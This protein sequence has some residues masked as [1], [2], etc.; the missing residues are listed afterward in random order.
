MMHRQPK[1]Y[2]NR[3]KLTDSEQG[4]AV[5]AGYAKTMLENAPIFPL[6]LEYK[7][8]DREMLNFCNNNVPIIIKGKKVPTFT[9][10]S[11]QRFSE[12]SQ[13]WKYT[14]E[15]NNILLNFK[16]ITRENN[17]KK[18]TSHGN[19]W[20]I[21]G[22]NRQTL[23]IRDVLDDNGTESYE[24][25]SMCQPFTVDIQYRISFVTD[26]FENLNEF[27]TIF[28]NLFKSRQFYIRPNGH[29][30]PLTLEDISDS[31]EYT[32]SDLKLY[33]QTV[34]I[35]CMAYIIQEKDFKI[36][37]VPKNHKLLMQGDTKSMKPKINLEEYYQDKIENVSIDLS[38][39]FES[40][41]DKVVFDIDTDFNVETVELYN[42][43]YARI[44]VNDNIGTI[45]KPFNLKNGDNI[46]IRITHIDP[47]EKARIILKG[48]NPDKT[49]VVDDV[50]IDA[51]KEEQRFDDIEIV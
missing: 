18:G 51:D 33:R 36:D 47:Q 37:K 10:Y 32:I 30:I 34:T 31:T 35:K 4:N 46:R 45:N 8:I 23:L 12:Y 7:D 22:E 42:I 43:R 11:N 28:H 6:P 39:D 38:V 26:L 49:Y 48:Y 41:H 2:I 19:Y 29:Y 16:T 17:P 13:T 15:E 27:N 21:P 9:L 20:N 5:R 1:K 24:I 40:W 3:V 14:D 50:P 44:F 25:Y